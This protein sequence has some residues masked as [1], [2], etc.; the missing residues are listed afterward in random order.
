MGKIGNF[1]CRQ[2]GKI[3]DVLQSALLKRLI[4]SNSIKE[5]FF[6]RFAKKI[7]YIRMFYFEKI[8]RN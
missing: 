3:V 2:S 5:K 1:N 4:D 7:P 8:F 6:T